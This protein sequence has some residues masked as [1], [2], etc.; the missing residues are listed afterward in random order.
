MRESKIELLVGRYAK[1][2]GCL[3]W[4]FAS[5]GRKGVPDRIIVSPDGHVL[6]MEL[7]T[8][9]GKVSPLQQFQMKVLK[10]NSANVCCV[11]SF[12]EAVQ[13]IESF[14]A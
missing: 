4:K 2:K 10:Q 14:L 9:R 6:F 1:S 11:F 3:Y 12:E 13:A 5:P 7:K 8:K